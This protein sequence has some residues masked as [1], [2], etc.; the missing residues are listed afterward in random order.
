ML[1]F[2]GELFQSVLLIIHLLF[3]K[4]HNLA[5]GTTF[6]QKRP[7]VLST[8][9]QHHFPPQKKKKKGKEEKKIPC[10]LSA[11]NDACLVYDGRLVID[12]TFHTNDACIRAAGPVTK[13]QRKYH[14]DHCT[15]ANFN[16]KEVGTQVSKH[17]I[18]SFLHKS[19]CAPRNSFA[20]SHGSYS[21]IVVKEPRALTHEACHNPVRCWLI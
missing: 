16:S 12:A 20:S 3:E 8:L 6:T 17:C 14:A 2:R 5:G 11:V 21:K 15:H 10:P 18:I 7:V 19:L 4:G 13:F 9:L 1:A